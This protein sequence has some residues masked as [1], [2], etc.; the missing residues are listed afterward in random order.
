M[1]HDQCWLHSGAEV[2]FLGLGSQWIQA[3]IVKSNLVA[4][5]GHAQQVTRLSSI[6]R[7]KG[8]PLPLTGSLR[9]CLWVTLL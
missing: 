5:S 4:A 1:L 2:A 3:V 9:S 7:R 8:S 6:H